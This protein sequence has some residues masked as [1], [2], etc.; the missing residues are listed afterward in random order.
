MIVA[1]KRLSQWSVVGWVNK[2]VKNDL[3]LFLVSKGQCSL[4]MDKMADNDDLNLLIKT[5]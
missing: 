3:E 4:A 5:Y 1:V 2:N